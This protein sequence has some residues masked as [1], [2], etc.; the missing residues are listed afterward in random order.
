[1][2]HYKEDA[3]KILLGAFE[4]VAKPWGMDGIREDFAFDQLPE[5][6]DH[7]EPILEK[8][9]Q[10]MPMLSDAGIHTFF[11]GPESFTPDDRYYLGEVP[12]LRGFWVAAGYNSIGIISSGGAAG[13]NVA[14]CVFCAGGTAAPAWLAAGWSAGAGPVGRAVD[15]VPGLVVAGA[16]PCGVGVAVAGC[17]AA[18]AV[19]TGT[20]AAAAESP[21]NP[22]WPAQYARTRS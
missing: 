15:G 20:G 11:N 19:L 14:G 13:V 22:G 2:R 16:C 17:C 3:G 12:E 10:R 7:F 18:G 5:D 9:I 1:M 4:P 8:A 21:P 6:F